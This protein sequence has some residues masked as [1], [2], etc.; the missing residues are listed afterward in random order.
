MLDQIIDHSSSSFSCSLYL[1]G[2]S[3]QTDAIQHDLYVVIIMIGTYPLVLSP[4]PPNNK[5]RLLLTLGAAAA[6]PAATPSNLCPPSNVGK[7]SRARV[8]SVIMVGV[9][10]LEQVCVH[11]SHA[12]HK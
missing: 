9:A 6:P 3:S 11:A 5:I 4:Q 2:V 12:Q 8:R 1:R 7:F 10:P